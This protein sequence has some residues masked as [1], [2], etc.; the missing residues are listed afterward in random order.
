MTNVGH[1]RFPGHVATSLSGHFTVVPGRPGHGAGFPRPCATCG[2]GIIEAGDRPALDPG[3]H[4]VSFGAAVRVTHLQAAG[5]S[6]L[7][8]KGLYNQA[9]GQYKLQTSNGVPSCVIAGSRGRIVVQ[10]KTS[11]ADGN[12]HSVGCSRIRARV[13]LRVDGTI[14]GRLR[15]QTGVVSNA[16]PV[17]VG[18][19]GLIKSNDQYHGNLDGVYIRIN[20]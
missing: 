8:Q 17:R 19:L 15:G 14:V 20:L 18:G 4:S 16:A 11:I 13:T 2:R 7:V 9:G 3:Q 10:S 6:N 5:E 1:P 12:W